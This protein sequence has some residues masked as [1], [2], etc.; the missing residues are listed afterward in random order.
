MLPRRPS[1]ITMVDMDEGD[2]AATWTPTGTL[3]SSGSTSTLASTSMSNGRPSPG[4]RDLMKTIDLRDAEPIARGGEEQ[5][6]F[7]VHFPEDNDN[8]DTRTVFE[9]KRPRT[10]RGFR[11][12]GSGSSSDV[13]SQNISLLLVT[14]ARKLQFLPV[15]M[16]GAF[17]RKIVQH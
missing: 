17:A 5:F 3:V 10:S 9:E 15:K 7:I 8:D 11:K 14:V 1:V 2:Y 6:S 13:K 4:H 12:G 16:R